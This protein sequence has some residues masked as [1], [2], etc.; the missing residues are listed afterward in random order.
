MKIISYISKYI[1]WSFTPRKRT[2]FNTLLIFSSSLSFPFLSHNSSIDSF[3][4]FPS[5]SGKN[6]NNIECTIVKIAKLNKKTQ[7]GKYSYINGETTEPIFPN[8][9]FIPKFRHRTGVG[10]I[11]R[12]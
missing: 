5:V 1:Y 10:Y 3:I 11:S 7:L 12:V 4:G 8:V 9:T 6:I 2:F